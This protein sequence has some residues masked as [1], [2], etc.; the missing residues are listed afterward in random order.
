MLADYGPDE[1]LTLREACAL[2]GNRFKL[3]TLRAAHSR[4]ELVL[5]RLG[6][7]DFVTPPQ[8]TQPSV[9]S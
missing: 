7:K 9:S 6:N 1:P 2:Y 5:E 4:G 8:Q 3:A